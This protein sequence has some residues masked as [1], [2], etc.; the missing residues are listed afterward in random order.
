[1]ARGWCNTHY[2]RWQ[3]HG[4]PL[5]G[6]ERQSVLEM[7]TERVEKHPDGCWHWTGPVDRS[8]YAVFRAH[9]K[10]FRG[11]RWAY[12]HFVGPIP[13]GLVIDHLCRVHGC[14][15][16]AHLEP[17]TNR[18]NVLRGVGRAAQNARKSHCPSGHEL[19][20]DNVRISGRRRYCRACRARRD[21][22]RYERLRIPIIPLPEGATP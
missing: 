5:G 12:E 17:V 15:N 21:K 1:M 22:R 9:G 7:F 4:D 14:V 13:A 2:T 11:H 6:H 20:G 18:E 19:A 3:R 10:R 8:G 16:P